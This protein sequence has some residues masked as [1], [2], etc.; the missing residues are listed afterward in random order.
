MGDYLDYLLVFL[1]SMAPIGELRLAIP[2]GL[3]NYDLAW[4]AVLPLAVLG[5][6]LVVL[7]IL[8]GLDVATRILQSFPNPLGRLLESYI[9]FVTARH[10]HRLKRYGTLGLV[11]FVG[12][13]LPWTGAWT[14]TLLAWSLQLPRFPAFL[15]ISTGVAVAGIVVTALTVTG[16][17]LLN[18]FR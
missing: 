13:P 3:V 2:L 6:I 10:S 14:G 7:P 11:P 12:I 1:A 17:T 5:N 18:I 16:Q 8:W 15:A 4:Y 9:S